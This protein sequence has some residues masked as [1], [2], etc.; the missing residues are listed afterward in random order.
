[1]EEYVREE[2]PTTVA[3]ISNV[4]T[5]DVDDTPGE[6]D[7][8][9]AAPETLS[10]WRHGVVVGNI[11]FALKLWARA[12]PGWQIATANPGVKLGGDLDSLRGPDVGAIRDD[13]R[14]TERGP[15]GWLDGAPDLVV[16]VAGDAHAPT[17]LLGEALEYLDAG[18]RLVWIVDP[19]AEQVAVFSAGNVVELVRDGSVDASAVLPG[20]A[21]SLSDLFE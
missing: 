5:F 3:P 7:P 8:E 10:T 15:N 21:C 6:P 1:M 20:F 19:I 9:A 4:A 17:E 14:P 12:N 18:A 11:V 2:E 16:E 13:N